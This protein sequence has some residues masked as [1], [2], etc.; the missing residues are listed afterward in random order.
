M[1][2]LFSYGTLQDSSVQLATFGR[3]VAGEPDALIGFR[4]DW[5][6]IT[7]PYVL[8]TSGK[9][10]HPIVTQTDNPDDRV[11]GT[12]FA[13]SPEDIARADEYEVDDYMRASV[14]LASGLTAWLYVKKQSSH[15]AVI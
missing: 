2:Y 12:V 13:L 3:Q 1:E 6:Q 4:Q 14:L 11:Q 7:D 8:K 15:K 10:H 9:T 5:V